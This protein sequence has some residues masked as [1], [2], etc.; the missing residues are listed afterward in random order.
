[1]PVHTIGGPAVMQPPSAI[2]VSEH[3]VWLDPGEQ[4][5]VFRRVAWGEGPAQ[6]PIASWLN[7]DNM[8]AGLGETCD[9]SFGEFALPMYRGQD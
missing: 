1:M 3:G 2:P 7:L 8:F 9:E 5:P 6:D 4:V